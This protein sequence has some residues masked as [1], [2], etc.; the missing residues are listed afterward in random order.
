MYTLR[1]H[2]LMVYI[3]I[4]RK[5]S[6]TVAPSRSAEFL[7]KRDRYSAPLVEVSVKTRQERCSTFDRYA[8]KVSHKRD[9]ETYGSR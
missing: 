4:R 6:Q 7:L 3:D 1:V 9:A 5:P 8:V 2:R